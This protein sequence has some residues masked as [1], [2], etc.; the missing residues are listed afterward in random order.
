MPSRF[1]LDVDGWGDQSVLREIQRVRP[2]LHVFGHFHAAYG[3]E[4][5]IFDAFERA[6][7][8]ARVGSWKALCEMIYNFLVSRLSRRQNAG[9]WSVNAALFGGLRDDVL[10]FP[11]S[12]NL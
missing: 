8:A 1:Y 10:Q 5:V 4:H 3:K 11:I 12:I 7:E 2:L 6:Y 9:T